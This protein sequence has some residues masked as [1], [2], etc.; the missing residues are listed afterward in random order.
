MRRVV[1]SLMAVVLAVT[2]VSLM[3]SYA[4][5]A[6]ER[7]RGDMEAVEAY[8]AVTKITRGTPIETA[9]AEGMLRKRLIPKALLPGEIDTDLT[10]VPAQ[11]VALH[12]IAA[13][14]FTPTTSFGPPETVT[15]GLPLPPGAM[16]VSITLPDPA[17]IAP[18]LRPGAQIAVFDTSDTD[19][20]NGDSRITRVL[21]PRVTVLAV[22]SAT[23]PSD[24]GE[25]SALITLA[26]D[27]QQAEKLIHRV[28]TGSL[29]LALV[30]DA[31]SVA[32]GPGVNDISVFE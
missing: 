9:L 12:E 30:N 6:D 7:A 27:Q 23:N 16:A 15:A 25:E 11:Y 24:D 29:Y 13:D 28:Q 32:P 1:I 21:L 5:A 22:G 8:V 4:Q 14:Q 3:V 2:G 19:G 26:L 10:N 31:S 20:N 17:R 18:F